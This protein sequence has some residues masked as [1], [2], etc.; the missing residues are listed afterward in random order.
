MS[1]VSNSTNPPPAGGS[2][3]NH[4]PTPL[5]RA[6]A[7]LM[8][9]EGLELAQLAQVD[10]TEAKVLRECEKE[11]QEGNPDGDAVVEQ[12]KAALVGGNH[13]TTCVRTGGGEGG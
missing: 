7:Y 1:F 13:L 2:H 5:P 10:N 9:V 12:L 8:V 4:L 6:T 3:L 11:G